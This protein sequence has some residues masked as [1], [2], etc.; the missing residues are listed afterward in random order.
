MKDRHTETAFASSHMLFAFT[1]THHFLFG[2]NVRSRT[3]TKGPNDP[4]SILFI[5]CV[6]DYEYDFQLMQEKG[7]IRHKRKHSE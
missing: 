4:P 1:T 2:N 7:S 5:A 6:A 3:K